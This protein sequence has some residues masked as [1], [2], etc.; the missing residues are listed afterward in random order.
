M[1]AH[2]DSSRQVGHAL[3]LVQGNDLILTLIV[4]IILDQGRVLLILREILIKADVG[5]SVYLED[6]VLV[7][8]FWL[9]FWVAKASPLG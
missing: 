4:Q 2:V 8:L 5:V 7:A 9:V 1:V 3:P 6:V